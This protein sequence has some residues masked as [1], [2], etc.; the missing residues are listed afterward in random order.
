MITSVTNYILL[1]GTAVFLVSIGC[2]ITPS[3]SAQGITRVS[4]LPSGPEIGLDD[5][6]G[7]TI[8]TSK[9]FTCLICGKTF[10]SKEILDAH[11]QREHDFK[12]IPLSGVG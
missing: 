1:I 12:I 8:N 7:L 3:V 11:K 5:Q 2:M 9:P 10:E 4:K 6:P